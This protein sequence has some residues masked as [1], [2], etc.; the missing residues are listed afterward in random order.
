MELKDNTFVG[1]GLPGMSVLLFSLWWTIQALWRYRDSLLPNGKMYVS[2][3]SFPCTNRRL[4]IVHLEV[5]IK[6]VGSVNFILMYIIGT[7]I[8][9]RVPLHGESLQ[10]ILIFIFTFLAALVEI[11]DK[12]FRY[13]PGFVYAA[14]IL[15][16]VMV[17][18][19]FSF[20]PPINPTVSTMHSLLWYTI[21][22]FAVGFTREM[23]NRTNV[24]YTLIR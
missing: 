24:V 17:A 5:W 9:E 20:H 7:L 6:L 11:L 23:I 8:I 19:I 16:L 22:L 2:T 3:V 1:H 13:P 15:T 18:F 21:I 14:H 12:R 4:K 10:H